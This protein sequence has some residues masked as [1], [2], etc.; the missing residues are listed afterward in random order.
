MLDETREFFLN[1]WCFLC[2]FHQGVWSHRGHNK[3]LAF[4]WK[5]CVG[6]NEISGVVQ[7]I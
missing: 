2:E 3:Q 7:T 1:G 4:V 5:V 6:R